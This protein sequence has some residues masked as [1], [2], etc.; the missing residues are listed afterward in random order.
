M[1]KPDTTIGKREYKTVV[2]HKFEL[3]QVTSKSGAD[4]ILSINGDLCDFLALGIVC[5]K[6]SIENSHGGKL[7]LFFSSDFFKENTG[8]AITHNYCRYEVPDNAMLQDE[9]FDS[10]NFIVSNIVEDEFQGKKFLAAYIIPSC[11]AHIYGAI[12]NYNLSEISML[13]GVNPNTKFLRRKNFKSHKL[14]PKPIDRMT[15][16]TEAENLAFDVILK[17]M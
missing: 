11:I 12:E 8:I 6:K 9:I 4:L 5:L 7:K 3:E 13:S 14:F 15:K 16:V 17:C 10:I 2:M 1:E